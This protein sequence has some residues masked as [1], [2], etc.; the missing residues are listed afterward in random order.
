MKQGIFVSRA[1]GS[2]RILTPAVERRVNLLNRD[3]SSKYLS[4]EVLLLV[5]FCQSIGGCYTAHRDDIVPTPYVNTLVTPDLSL[6]NAIARSLRMVDITVNV[7]DRVTC[8]SIVPH[9]RMRLELSKLGEK[10]TL[11]A[12]EPVRNKMNFTMRLEQGEKYRFVLKG[13]DKQMLDK[14]V[15]ADGRDIR[16]DFNALCRQ[17]SAL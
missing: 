8:F 13:L 7:L 17:E 12:I 4:Y 10:E 2:G 15:I 16:L 11:K 14:V 9:N 6:P 3:L 5:F 1:S